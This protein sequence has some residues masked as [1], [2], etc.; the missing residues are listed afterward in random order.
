M[1]NILI[2]EDTKHHADDA[3]VAMQAAGFSLGTGRE[4]TG[5]AGKYDL[6][7]NLQ[8]ALWILEGDDHYAG[9]VTDIF[10]P[11]GQTREGT[12]IPGGVS[13]ALRAEELGIPFVF[14]TSGYHHGDQYQWIHELGIRRKW[15]R[16]VD[17]LTKDDKGKRWSKAI[18]TLLRQISGRNGGG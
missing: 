12:L 5:S 13:I 8:S 9:I 3:E 18:E 15:P 7:D 4:E 14:C 10:M 6:V 2:I 17:P 11:D 1:L 16:M